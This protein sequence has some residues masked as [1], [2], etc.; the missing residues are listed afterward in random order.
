MKFS[1]VATSV[2][3]AAREL[4]KYYHCQPN[5]NVNA[6]LYDIKE[7]FQGRNDSGKMNNK[8]NDVTYMNLIGTLR[9]KLKLLAIEIEPMVYKYEFLKI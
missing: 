5:C 6:S 9:D 7:H 8:S 4:W 1:K 2:F 3:D